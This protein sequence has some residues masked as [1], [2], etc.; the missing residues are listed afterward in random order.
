MADYNSL[1]DFWHMTDLRSNNNVFL[2]S[3]FRWRYFGITDKPELCVAV[4]KYHNEE[5]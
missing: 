5:Q 4:I 3:D 1:Y 2:Q